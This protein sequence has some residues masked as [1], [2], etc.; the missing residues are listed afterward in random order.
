MGFLS[1]KHPNL[2]TDINIKPLSAKQQKP[3][4]NITT[5]K[6]QHEQQQQQRGRQN[7]TKPIKTAAGRSGS[8]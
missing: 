8:D 1:V 6:Q 5:V 4:M 3:N 2:M 7:Q